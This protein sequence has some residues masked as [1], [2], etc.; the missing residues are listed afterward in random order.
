MSS[1]FRLETW[2][3]LVAQE[4]ARQAAAAEAVTRHPPPTAPTPR[5]ETQ[6]PAALPV[7]A[8]PKTDRGRRQALIALAGA[9]AAGALVVTV[10]FTFQLPVVKVRL[11]GATVPS[12]VLL[13]ASGIVTS[14]PG[15]LVSRTVNVAEVR[16][17]L[18]WPEIAE[19]TKFAASSSAMLTVATDGLIT[20]Y[21]G[22]AGVSV[23]MTV[24]VGSTV[25]LSIT[26]TAI[27]ADACPIGIVTDPESVAY[28]AP[29][30]AVPET[31]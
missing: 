23:T 21:V 2:D 5:A 10:W 22:A 12:A 13:L 18:V 11:E 9:F 1:K 8:T 3:E 29:G 24:W 27:A 7:D 4:H 31:V 25:K 28:L 15:L 26:V 30:T 19:T 16:F 6:A 14:A 17:S 20:V